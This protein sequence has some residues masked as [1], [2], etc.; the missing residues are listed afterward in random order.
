MSESIIAGNINNMCHY[1]G[2][3]VEEPHRHHIFGAANRK[4]SEKYGLWVYLCPEHHNMSKHS[5]H[6][7]KLM[8]NQYHY[9]GQKTFEDW[10][11]AKNQTTHEVA[12]SEFMR[13]FGKNY[14]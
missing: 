4:W 14:I 7:D 10:Y 13:I 6:F 8:M 5:V 12:R 2:R 9:L 11:M 3:Y 1:C